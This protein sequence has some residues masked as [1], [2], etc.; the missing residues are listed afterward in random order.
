MD[1]STLRLYIAEA[2]VALHRLMTGTAT[3]EVRDSSGELIR[4][5]NANASRL[6]QYL[7]DLKAQLADLLAARPNMRGP[8]RPM[9]L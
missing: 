1:E 9:F 6:R 8:M 2:E 3:V 4:F 7:A 5:N